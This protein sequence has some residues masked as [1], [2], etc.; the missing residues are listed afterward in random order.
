[1]ADGDCF[2][3][4][5]GEY[6]YDV[7]DG[8]RG[9]DPA[10]RPNQL[11]ALALTHS[12]CDN[13]RARCIVNACARALLTSLGLRTLAPRDP[14]YG[15]RF[16]GGVRAR[17][18]A[19]H[20]GTSWAWLIGPFVTAHFRAFGDAAAARSF[21]APFEHHLSDAGLGT[22]SEVFDGDAPYVP[23][24]CIA[25]AWSVAEVLRAWVEVAE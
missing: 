9:D 23:G 3:Y 12:P 24:G 25:Q 21:L 19:Y 16:T 5:E 11:F 2:W 7:V 4:A 8:P 22:I 14:R 1:M 18:G 13:G 20:Q 10:L 15:G 17:D 6:L